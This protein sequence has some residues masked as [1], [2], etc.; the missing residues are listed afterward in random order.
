MESKYLAMSDKALFALTLAGYIGM[1]C[2]VCKHEYDSVVDIDNRD[3]VRATKS[4]TLE[5]A[6]KACFDEMLLNP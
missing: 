1:R 6:C 3:P 5:L 4:E 2:C